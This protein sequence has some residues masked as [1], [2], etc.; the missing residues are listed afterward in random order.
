MTDGM[1]RHSIQAAL[2]QCDRK[3]FFTPHLKPALTLDLIEMTIPEKPSR[4]QRYRLT[5]KGR[6]VLAELSVY[7]LLG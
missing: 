3:S 7:H 4:L 1:S 6:H 2:G 5:D